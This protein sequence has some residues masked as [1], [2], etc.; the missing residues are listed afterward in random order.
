MIRRI[1]NKYKEIKRNLN[2]YFRQK[3][4]NWLHLTLITETLQYQRDEISRQTETINELKKVLK[5]RT[6][7]HLDVHH[8]TKK[9]S[10]VILIG[11]YGRRDFIKCYSISDT[12]L[13]ELISHCRYL[14]KYASH[15]RIDAM[16]GID[17]TI[18]ETLSREGY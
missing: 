13:Q 3:A 4:C 8:E 16:P 1:K 2:S 15:G 14:E 6:E 9:N 12:S 11:K 10:Q 18:D 7:Y 17:V 5:E